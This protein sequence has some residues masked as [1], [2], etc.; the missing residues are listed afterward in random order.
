MKRHSCASTAALGCSPHG[1]SIPR[2]PKPRCNAVWR[3]WLV[4]PKQKLATERHPAGNRLVPWRGD[5]GSVRTRAWWI[6]T[7]AGVLAIVGYFLLARD[8]EA[9]SW[10]YNA[11]GLVSA[12]AMAVGTWRQPPAA[13][14]IWL[15]FAVGTATWSIG[16]VIYTYYQFHLNL[17]PYPSPA[18]VF[19]LGAYGLLIPGLLLLVRRQSTVGGTT[20]MLDASI[21]ATSVG[22]LFWSLVM[23]P[24]IG[25]NSLSTTVKLISL[26]YP[27]VDALMLAIVVRILAGGGLRNPSARLLV[28]AVILLLGS[29]IAYSIVTA[30]TSYDGGLFDL[31]WLLSYVL[32]AAAALHPSA[33]AKLSARHSAPSGG[34]IRLIL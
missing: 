7:M 34:R 1:S 31:G 2:T 26:T 17:D 30:H 21:V 12:V 32:W 23:Q 28:A 16:D 25:D 5:A 27:A 11:I 22:L 33:G 18:D 9:R 19:Y 3:S 14:R 29:D 15:M 20:A 10:L 13:R 24:I 8:S 6:W 4:P